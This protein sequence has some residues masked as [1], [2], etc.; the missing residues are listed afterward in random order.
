LVV[1]GVDLTKV[2]GLG[3]NPVVYGK[4]C[5]IHKPREERERESQPQCEAKHHHRA[6][7][8]I[9]PCVCMKKISTL[10][11]PVTLLMVVVV[12]TTGTTLLAY[13]V[14]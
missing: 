6:H 11:P 9:M 4:M 8:K 7:D 10:I 13:R 5:E 12:L 1:G 3:N 14:P 2:G